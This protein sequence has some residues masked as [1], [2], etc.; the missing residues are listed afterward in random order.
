M[1]PPDAARTW[2]RIAPVV[3][4]AA[5]LAGGTAL[6]V[7]L[8]HR[9][10]RDLDFFFHEDLDLESFA[11]IL[12]TT[13][14]YA[15]EVRDEDTLNGTFSATRLQFLSAA[16]QRRLQP[17]STVADIEVAGLSDI[18]AMKLKAIGDRGELRDYFDVMTIE[19]E[20]GRTVEEGLS[21]YMARFGVP[22]DH[23][24]LRHI[25]TG[26]GYFGDVTDDEALPLGREEIVSYWQR[27]QPDIIRN[28]ARFPSGPAFRPAA[29]GTSS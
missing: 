10:S 15:V 26:L 25:V 3:P 29:P 8:G 24:S 5:Y 14:P 6:A 12:Q 11:R 4:P 17:S 18:F 13:G 2:E 9:V 22:A 28:V 27:R 20:T 16:G 19:R 1:L 7:H 21:L 23:L